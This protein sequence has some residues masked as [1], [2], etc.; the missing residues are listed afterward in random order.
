MLDFYQGSVACFSR[1][2]RSPLD[3]LPASRGVPLFRRRG[4]GAPS[5]A[6]RPDLVARGFLVAVPDA[7]GGATDWCDRHLR[8]EVR[9]ST[10]SRSAA[11]IFRRSGRRC[12]GECSLADQRVARSS[13]ASDS[14]CRRIR[15]H[16]GVV[17]DMSILA[18]VLAN[19]L[20]LRS[21]ARAF[22]TAGQ[23]PPSV[24]RGR[25]MA[26]FFPRSS[27]GSPQFSWTMSS[28]SPSARKRVGLRRSFSWKARCSHRR[29]ELRS[30]C[31]STRPKV[32]RLSDD[33]RCLPMLR[34]GCC[35]TGVLTLAR[36]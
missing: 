35:P 33:S 16:H 1:R 21:A 28:I 2:P 34:E 27:Y 36:S 14:H 23:S 6:R 10:E 19:S 32:G 29:C 9:P 8:Q 24:A 25:K 17:R 13:P 7:E 12:D 26:N 15:G 18:T 3:R 30:R 31:T 22:A 11:T 20:S 4:G 5:R